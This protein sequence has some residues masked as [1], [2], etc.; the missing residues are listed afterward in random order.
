MGQLSVYFPPGTL[1]PKAEGHAR[2]DA[3]DL[4]KL[5]FVKA[6]ADRGVGPRTSFM[7][8]EICATGIVY[9]ALAFPEA[10]TNTLASIVQAGIVPPTVLQPGQLDRLFGDL[11]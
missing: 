1:L 10:Y 11:A 5:F 3:Y 4:A 7:N 9:H 8:A 2:F 6:M